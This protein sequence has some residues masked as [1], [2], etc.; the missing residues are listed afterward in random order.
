MEYI[1]SYPESEIM[2][3]WDR[4]FR[5][6]YKRRGYDLDKDVKKLPDEAER[7]R[8]RELYKD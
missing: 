4:L 7:E 8:L 3:I 1:F 6:D 2:Q 5:E